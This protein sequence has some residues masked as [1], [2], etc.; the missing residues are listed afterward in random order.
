VEASGGWRLRCGLVGWGKLL[1]GKA[2][3]GCGLWSQVRAEKGEGNFGV[4][5]EDADEEGED[6]EGGG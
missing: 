5:K 1:G 2:G 4:D 3:Y 6:G